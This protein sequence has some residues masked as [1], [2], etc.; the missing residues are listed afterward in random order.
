M[1]GA[2][3]AADIRLDLARETGPQVD[4][5]VDLDLHVALLELQEVLETSV[6]P[7][8]ISE[9]EARARIDA[10]T[11]LV[12]GDTAIAPDVLDHAVARVHHLIAER[13]P[14][15]T[16]DREALDPVVV[17]LALRGLLRP[18]AAA[19][20]P[21]V[22]DRRWRRAECPVCGGAPDFAVIGGPARERRLLC[23]RCDAEWTYSRIGCPFCG[24]AAPEK[25]GYYPA[26]TPRYRV[27]VCDACGTYLEAVDLA[28]GDARSA[29]A[30]R[31]LASPL[32]RA[33]AQLGYHAAEARAAGN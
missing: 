19:L 16:M 26:A 10:G 25:L 23:S 8:R 11:P 9:D 1:V 24:N 20:A 4:R 15:L 17:T 33:V 2:H 18:W 30:E 22:D 12:D 31:I 13:R 29:P 6:A 28:R 14:D 32:D 5:D 27:Y 7:P 3:R 21:L